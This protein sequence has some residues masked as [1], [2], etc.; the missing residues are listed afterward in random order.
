MSSITPLIQILL[1]LPI[2]STYLLRN[3]EQYREPKTIIYPLISADPSL[4]C[5]TIS[6]FSA[7][8]ERQEKI[9]YKIELSEYSANFKMS[10][11]DKCKTD[12]ET[13]LNYSAD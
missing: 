8:S 11:K 3:L 9:I 7:L 2:H 13:N 6:K 10:N 5:I 12:G 4:S 1:F